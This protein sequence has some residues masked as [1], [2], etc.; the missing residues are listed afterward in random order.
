MKKATLHEIA[1]VLVTKGR[2]RL[3]KKIMGNIITEF[4]RGN[5]IITKY[6]RKY[7]FSLPTFKKELLME[8]LN[9][10][11][12]WAA[13]K[14][15]DRNS[16]RLDNYISFILQMVARVKHTHPDIKKYYERLVKVFRS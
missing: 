14:D 12:R 6:Y 15:L 11:G 4:T 13:A 9:N 3:A 8:L 7:G 16:N 5:D 1:G 10:H 2:P